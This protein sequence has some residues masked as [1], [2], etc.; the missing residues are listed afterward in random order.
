MREEVH[1]FIIW[2]KAR[3]MQEQIIEDIQKKFLILEIYS[4]E[5][6]QKKFSENLTRFYGVKLG[7]HSGK[8]RHCGRGGF[9]LIL[10]KDLR[11]KYELRRTSRGA[12]RVNINLFDAKAKYREWTGGGHKIHATNSKEEVRHD[13]I[14]LLGIRLEE[15]EK[16][17]S[18]KVWDGS[19]TKLKKDLFGAYGWKCLEQAFEVLNE[20]TNYLV[21]R[22]YE[23]LPEECYIGGHEDIDLLAENQREVITLLNAVKY[24]KKKYRVQYKILVGGKEVLLDIRYL[25]DNYYD[26]IWQKN[27]MAGRIL[28]QN[29]LYI[30]NE[31]DYFYSLLY[32]ALIHKPHLSKDYQKRLIKMEKNLKLSPIDTEILMKNL[33]MQYMELC[34]YEFVEPDDL[35]VYFNWKN[36]KNNV[37]SI[38]RKFFL[39]YVMTKHT[40]NKKIRGKK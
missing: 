14:L 20:T 16:K 37:L 23:G 8:E 3:Y 36:T 13:L 18:T 38:K 17:F 25:G 30:M 15:Y 27:M 7:K 22:N 5:W 6:S 29:W 2:E 21:M 24:G 34:Q 39:G 32:H 33:L 1:I 10:I 11:P 35:S 19:V 26:A 9:L 28:Y 12:E 4:V 40:I 31:K